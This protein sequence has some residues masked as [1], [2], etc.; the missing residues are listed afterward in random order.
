M[1]QY[2][3][4]PADFDRL[5]QSVSITQPI[6]TMQRTPEW[7]A[8]RRGRFTGSEVHK[9][10]VDPRSKTEEVS[11]TAMTYIREKLAELI[12]GITPQVSSASMEWGTANEPL[13]IARYSEREGV[14]IIP[15]DFVP[16]G[17][18]GGGSPD[19]YID[20]FA[21]VEVKCPYNSAVHLDNLLFAAS[22]P[23]ADDFK[24]QYRE[25]YW[26]VQNNMMATGKPEAIFI[27]FDPRF[28]EHQ[29]LAVVRI[30]A[31]HSDMEILA[32]RIVRAARIMA[33]MKREL[34]V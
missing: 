18:Y 29:Q 27:S 8:A 21:I 2:I 28:P 24:T 23:T 7:Y 6:G 19:G 32:D 34:G 3:P 30:P 4:H 26:Q 5:D 20:P 9:L 11:A 14:E 17:Q 33:E 25:Y 31:V 15:A 22:R 10:M 12:T 13:A 16:F 1:N